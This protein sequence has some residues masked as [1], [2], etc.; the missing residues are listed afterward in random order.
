MV[1]LELPMVEVVEDSKTVEAEAV[2]TFTQEHFDIRVLEY[3]IH[4]TM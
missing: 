2:P 4:F 3:Q 1:Y